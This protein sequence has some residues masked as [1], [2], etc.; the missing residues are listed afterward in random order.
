MSNN[1]CRVFIS[2]ARVDAT[3]VHRDII[4]PLEQANV[5]VFIDTSTA[6]GERYPARFLK[7]I[8]ECDGLV[9]AISPQSCASPACQG[10][11]AYARKR[12]IPILPIIIAPTSEEAIPRWLTDEIN[13]E[14]REAETE[15]EVERQRERDR[16]VAR[17]VSAVATLP[18]NTRRKRVWQWYG[19]PLAVL[20][21]MIAVIVL[22]VIALWAIQ[23]R[24][25]PQA[26]QFNGRNSSIPLDVIEI[27]PD[28][29]GGVYYTSDV[30]RSNRAISDLYHLSADQIATPQSDDSGS[31]IVLWPPDSGLESSIRD[32]VVDCH[33]TL[34]ILFSNPDGPT[35]AAGLGRWTSDGGLQMITDGVAPE[36]LLIFQY[37]IALAARCKDGAAGTV[38][39][40]IAGYNQVS[41]NARSTTIRTLHID[42][43]GTYHLPVPADDDL[44][45]RFD[46]NFTYCGSRAVPPE[47]R[48]LVLN[49]ERDL[50]Y[51][52][53][54]Q[55]GVIEFAL[56]EPYKMAECQ[57]FNGPQYTSLGEVS[58]MAVVTDGNATIIA[59]SAGLF[60]FAG[61]QLFSSGLA[62]QPAHLALGDRFLWSSNPCGVDCPERLLT[63]NRLWFNE[64]QPILLAS[65]VTIAELV[66][67]PVG[68]RTW[69]ATSE[70][71]FAYQDG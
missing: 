70:G 52:V 30:S 24:A 22:V 18:R 55:Q 2:Y 49:A 46:T 35:E 11:L 66:W 48:A 42:P 27:A 57:T 38:D 21:G 13:Y 25:L 9:F 7:E 71:L 69:V 6:I 28:G 50:L 33:G 53:D 61:N 15:D 65:S 59:T 32:M 10:E 45:Y 26:I 17:L 36:D 20:S 60:S 16:R 51:V 23:V 64:Q 29:V 67:D 14:R 5:D 39:L 12:K 3:I 62:S 4:H 34:W 44:H 54:Y 8:R 31:L 63:H 58:P 41:T 37:G 47:I 1:V 68:R 43:N 19:L 40:Y 56:S